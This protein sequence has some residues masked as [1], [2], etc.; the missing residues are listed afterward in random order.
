MVNTF[1]FNNV[2]PSISSFS[3]NDRVVAGDESGGSY[4][5]GF[6]SIGNLFSSSV[7]SNIQASGSGGITFRTSNGTL[8]GQ[9]GG[10]GST[11]FNVPVALRVNSI[12]LTPEEGTWPAELA[13]ATTGGNVSNTSADFAN[14]TKVGDWC[15]LT[16]QFTNVDLTGLTLGNDVILRGLPF[17]A[18]NISATAFLFIGGV[19]TSVVTFTDQIHPVIL[20]NSNYIRFVQN[21]SGA[22]F[23]YTTFDDLGAGTS[24]FRVQIRY[25]T[26]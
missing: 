4:T 8:V 12:D 10:G 20:D 26:A 3:I 7:Y 13:D 21:E 15:D 14:Y 22:G 25:Q 1:D 19:M 11:T 24:T 2:K 16:C 9:F 18:K 17:N 5:L 23:S 6:G